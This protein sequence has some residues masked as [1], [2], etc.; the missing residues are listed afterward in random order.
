VGR[1]AQRRR[2]AKRARRVPPRAAPRPELTYWNGERCEAR[3]VWLIVGDDGRFERPWF[4]RFIGQQR[5]AVEV[6]YGGQTFY[7]D[8]AGGEGWF[9]VTEGRGSPR[10]GHGSLSPAP[11]SVKQR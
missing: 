9:K 11:G 2:E 3:K 6:V 8:D 5:A 4:K 10:L 7:L 1:N